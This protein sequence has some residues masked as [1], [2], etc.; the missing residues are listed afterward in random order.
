MPHTGSRPSHVRVR[1]R[2]RTIVPGVGTI[3]TRTAPLRRVSAQWG[4][5]NRMP[6]IR[7][8]HLS[9]DR[10]RDAQVAFDARAVA[11]TLRRVLPSGEEP[12]SVRLVKTTGAI[13]RSLR[14]NYDAGQLAEALVAGDPD[15]DLE[16]TGR[17]LS[18]TSRIFVD[19]NYEIVY[20][21][22][23]EQ[24]IFNPDGTERE[25]RALEKVPGNLNRPIPL[26]WT[27]R[28][29]PRG[30]ALR[31]FVFSRSYQLR[32]VNGATF[33][34]LFDMAARLDRADA[35]V[36]L[37]AGPKGSDPLLMSRGRQPYRGFLEGRVAGEKYCLILHLSDIELKG[38][39]EP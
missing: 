36:L 23:L 28:M 10:R 27:G 15:V 33:D 7:A 14:E 37:G 31:R 18:R 6:M 25:R 34:F 21:V 5:S 32:H 9:N 8:I 1:Q 12:V 13:E 17:K 2:R 22:N 4:S 20:H 30:E 35:M 29:F 19:R 26:R 16:T 24:V 3:L 38:L 11:S 39:D